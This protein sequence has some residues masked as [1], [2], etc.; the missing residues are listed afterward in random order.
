MLLYTHIRGAS[1][2]HFK[3]LLLYSLFKPF[4]I[5]TIISFPKQALSNSIYYTP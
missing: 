4:V 5:Q 2:S 3:S 1:D